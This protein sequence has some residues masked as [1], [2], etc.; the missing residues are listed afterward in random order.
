MQD[1]MQCHEKMCSEMREYY[2]GID[3]EQEI[4]MERLQAEIRKLKKAAQRHSEAKER[5]EASN[6]DHG[7]ELQD[8]LQQVAILEF[9]TKD[10]GKDSVSLENTNARLAVTRRLIREAKLNYSRLQDEYSKV[11]HE[12]DML[13][14]RTSEV[15]IEACKEN[16]EKRSM[17]ENK[18]HTQKEAHTTIE[19]HLHHIINSAG[20]DERQSNLLLSNLEEF[21][22]D[23][24]KITE[25]LTLEIATAMKSYHK[26]LECRQEELRKMHVPNE[27]VISIDILSRDQKRAGEIKYGM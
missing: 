20:L 1:L 12:R 15:A 27:E 4:E 23:N 21:I 8:C 10:L 2:E 19:Q 26:A 11:Q 5:L 16:I 13:R 25:K 18:I 7:K 17:L 24:D 22:A 9:K 14:A 3:R 6:Q